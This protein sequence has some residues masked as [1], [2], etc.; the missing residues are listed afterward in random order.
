[1]TNFFHT[2]CRHMR[3]KTDGVPHTV[4]GSSH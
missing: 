3:R 1:M 4:L 2:A